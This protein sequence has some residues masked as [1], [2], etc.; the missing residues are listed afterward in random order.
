MKSLRE[1][2]DFIF[3]EIKLRQK[4]ILDEKTQKEIKLLKNKAR[5]L[6]GK[7]VKIKVCYDKDSYS[8]GEG[9]IQFIGFDSLVLKIK[10]DKTRLQEFKLITVHYKDII[11]IT[12]ISKINS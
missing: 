11:S 6:L 1:E 8:E 2:R 5:R 7:M 3:D 12:E 4:K 10:Q 9:V